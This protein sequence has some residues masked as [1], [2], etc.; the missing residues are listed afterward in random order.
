T[1]QQLQRQQ[2]SQDQRLH[3]QTILVR[4]R[5]AFQKVAA[6]KDQLTSAQTIFAKINDHLTAQKQQIADLNQ[7]SNQLAEKLA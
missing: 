2:S 6:L 1:Q 4:Q 5:P 3:D 7:R